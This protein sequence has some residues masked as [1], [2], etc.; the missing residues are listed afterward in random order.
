MKFFSQKSI[1][2]KSA[3]FADSGRFSGWFAAFSSKAPIKAKIDRI[4]QEGN[5]YGLS[6]CQT[7]V[8]S[9]QFK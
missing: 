2:K 7:V 9:R 6:R 5:D 1:R 8:P 3:A 4:A